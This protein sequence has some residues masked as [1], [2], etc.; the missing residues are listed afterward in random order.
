M[1]TRRL[2]V[3]NILDGESDL[4]QREPGLGQLHQPG[5]AHEHQ[6]AHDKRQA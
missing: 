1:R 5:N 2:Q 4:K 3:A 6:D